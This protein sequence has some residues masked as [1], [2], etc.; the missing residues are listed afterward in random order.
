ML[1]LLL[2]LSVVA[3]GTAVAPPRRGRE[4]V[5]PTKPKATNLGSRGMIPKKKRRTG[6]SRPG[7]THGSKTMKAAKRELQR[8][9][10]NVGEDLG[11]LQYLWHRTIVYSYTPFDW[12]HKRYGPIAANAFGFVIIMAVMMLNRLFDNKGDRELRLKERLVI[13]KNTRV[14]VRAADSLEEYETAVAQIQEEDLSY[15]LKGLRKLFRLPPA[16]PASY[17]QAVKDVKKEVQPLLLTLPQTLSRTTAKSYRC[18]AIA[19]T[20]LSCRCPS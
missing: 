10:E 6:T 12:L 5:Q 13:A 15:P 14:R 17:S 9:R 4:V 16:D 19:A 20:L 7:N 11:W 2:Q 1:L 8:E 3:E 18:C